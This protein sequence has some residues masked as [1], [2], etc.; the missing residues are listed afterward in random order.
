MGRFLR[1]MILTSLVVL[2]GCE[3]SVLERVRHL[4][5]TAKAAAGGELGCGMGTVTLITSGGQV[6][7]EC[8]LDPI[9]VFGR[10]IEVSDLHLLLAARAESNRNGAGGPMSGEVSELCSV[11]LLTLSLAGDP[12][13]VGAIAPLLDDPSDVVR[14]WAAIALFRMARADDP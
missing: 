3:D 5:E 9:L 4:Q 11:C 6:V 12:E 8:D 14:G 7:A 10:V 2:G 1:G 13:S